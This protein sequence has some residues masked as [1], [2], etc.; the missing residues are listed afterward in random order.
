MTSSEN[1]GETKTP[2]QNDTLQAAAR[3][4]LGLCLDVTL[5]KPAVEFE[6]NGDGSFTIYTYAIGRLRAIA[7]N[8]SPV[9]VRTTLAPEN[10]ST[11]PRV[12]DEFSELGTGEDIYQE[13]EVKLTLRSNDIIDAEYHGQPAQ[14][15][16]LIGYSAFLEA[17]LRLG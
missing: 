7:L 14:A 2:E 3:K 15:A 11:T 9:W 10:D 4:L 16:N 6:D 5:A 13:P 8:C 12:F 17:S 1:Q